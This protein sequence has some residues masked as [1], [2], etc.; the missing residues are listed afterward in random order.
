MLKVRLS[1]ER[2]HFDHGWLKTYHT[3]S[4]ADYY[5]PQFVHFRSLR[6]INE[7]RVAPAEGFDEHPHEDMEIL[8]YVMSGAL[9]HKD[10]MGTGSVIKPGDVQI[11]SAGTGITHS[12]FNHSKTEAVHLLQ[13]WMMPNERKLKPRYDQKFFGVEDKHNRLKLI[14]SQKGRDGSIVI[15]QDID[16]YA[17]VV[18]AGTKLEFAPRK[19]SGVWIQ[20]I[21]GSVEVNGTVL[22]AGD[23]ISAQDE[24]KLSLYADA[25]SEFLLFDI[26]PF[27][28]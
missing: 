9:E 14:G 10:S 17:S 26:G 16:L 13:I 18:D 11:M 12:E 5:D 8:T 2:G 27:E 24:A 19:Y 15:H 25:K 20:M 22:K 6:V 21:H 23:A 1:D 7:D 28:P 3:F 4:F